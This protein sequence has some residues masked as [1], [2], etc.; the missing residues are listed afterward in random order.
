MGRLGQ[1]KR[2]G[3]ERP[4]ALMDGKGKGAGVWGSATAKGNPVKSRSH[5]SQ[6]IDPSSAVTRVCRRI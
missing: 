4:L 3:S 5:V 2:A 1:R 6:R